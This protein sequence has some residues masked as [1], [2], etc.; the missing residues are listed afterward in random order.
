VLAPDLRA[1][2]GLSLTE[3]G[4][5][6][7]APSIGSVTTL[8]AWGLAADRIGERLVIGAGLGAASV[9]MF[10]VAETGTFAR[11]VVLLL[12]A[13]AAGASVNSASGRA[14]MHWFD[15]DG[16][17]LALGLRQ[18][19]VPIAG[20]VVAL[21]LPPL[22]SRHDPSPALIALAVWLLAGALVGLAVIRERHDAV[23]EA[24]SHTADGPLRN[25]VIWR[26]AAASSLLLVPQ[27]CVIAFL[28]LF[29]HEHEG[30]STVAAA[31]VLAA[32]NVLGIGTRIGAGRWSDLAGS[33]VVPL[34]RIGL[35]SAALVLCCSVLAN[36]PLVLLVP[37]F[38]VMGCVAI[39]WNG[40]SFA[41]VAEAAG[42]ARSGSALG[43]QQTLL[44][45]SGAIVPIAFGALVAATS[46]RASFAVVAL[47]PLAG[48]RL[49]ATVS[50]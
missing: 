9:F 46:W 30:V 6:L 31:G 13:G 39:S 32:V 10:V 20:V 41:A 48:W 1:R 25:P 5:V 16:R 43:L 33:R 12:L 49:L 8:Y 7:A 15:A 2:Y 4:V 42:H 26:L 21:V 22:S 27:V 44:A 23:L 28:V 38:V 40:V 19:S 50:G 34:R 35:A 37:A 17:G 29:L 45:V 24:G 3:T 36:G 14:V 18:T 47:F 11:L